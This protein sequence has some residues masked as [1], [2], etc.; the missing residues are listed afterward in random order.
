MHTV[1]LASRRRSL[2]LHLFA[3]ISGQITVI[4]ER[5]H[6]HKF[7]ETAVVD[8]IGDIQDPGEVLNAVLRAGR[9]RPVDH[10]VASVEFAQASA[11][12]AR[13]SL[14]LPGIDYETAIA[15]SH[16]HIM[17]QRL[18]AAGVPTP[19]SLQA[20]T[21]EQIPH[22]ADELGWPCVVKPV[23]GGGNIDVAVLDDRADWDR[24]ANDPESE[25]LRNS[26]WPIAVEEYADIKN[27]YH[28]D[29]VVVEGDIRFA[30]PSRYFTPCL[31]PADTMRG[32]YVLPVDHPRH[33]ALLQLHRDVVRALG[34]ES[35][36]TH[37]E[38]YETAT[39]LTVGE[40]AC[41][42][43]GGRITEALRLQFGLDLWEVFL[44]LALG[45]DPQIRPDR[46]GPILAHA[47]LPAEPGLI[48]DLVPAADLEAIEGVLRAEM[49]YKVGDRIAAD[50]TSAST[51]GFVFY[52]AEDEQRV[53]RVFDRIAQAQYLEVAAE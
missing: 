23:F 18:S 35:G 32:S 7:P 37:L 33:D 24:L 3:K 30:A 19:A 17:K 15:F 11:G 13:T 51:T 28:C 34:L 52:E 9:R 14:G 5:G 36:I 22:L 41:R 53:H 16:K 38:V 43:A 46:R 27:E 26:H 12:F 49:P 31:C 10:I 42:P 39:G 1:V 45:R 50:L 6:S 48:V 29:G 20:W 47:L 25:R 8:Q 2:P 21:F 40:V 4:C 44:D